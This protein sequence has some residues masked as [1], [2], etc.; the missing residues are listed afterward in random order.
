MFA[1]FGSDIWIFA[2][3]KWIKF[4]TFNLRSMSSSSDA[5]SFFVLDNEM[6]VYYKYYADSSASESEFESE[7]S[8]TIVKAFDLVSGTPKRFGAISGR[9]ENPQFATFKGQIYVSHNNSAFLYQMDR[10]GHLKKFATNSQIRKNP[11]LIASNLFLYLY[12]ENGTAGNSYERFCFETQKFIPIEQLT[13]RKSFYYT[14]MDNKLYIYGGTDS[15]WH[16]LASC[17]VYDETTKK[18]TDIS[19]MLIKRTRFRLAA[20]NG[21]LYAIGGYD[22][23]N[24][25]VDYMEEYCPLKNEWKFSSPMPHMR[26]GNF[27]SA[28]VLKIEDDLTKLP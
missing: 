6:Y 4:L 1:I 25:L 12:S 14:C 20:H 5:A 10:K 16:A 28:G 26:K 27:Y 13:T 23:K 15:K 18:S 24:Q 19:P 21:K 9:F 7:I 22:E 17:E 11:T 3:D 8:Y 2:E